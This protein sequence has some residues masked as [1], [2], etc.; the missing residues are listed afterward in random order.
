MSHSLLG[1]VEKAVNLVLDSF[2]GH[3]VRAFRL[4]VNSSVA[5]IL[6][7]GKDGV[8]RSASDLTR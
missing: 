5:L 4:L 1:F 3:G 2:A 8:N 6:C 7:R